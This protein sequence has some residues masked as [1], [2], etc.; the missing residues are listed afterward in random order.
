MSVPN[1]R[2]YDDSFIKERLDEMVRSN[3]TTFEIVSWFYRFGF[4]EGQAEIVKSHYERTKHLSE[5]LRLIK[6][7]QCLSAML[8]IPNFQIGVDYAWEHAIKLIELNEQEEKR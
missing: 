6:E 7:N 5:Q 1:S 3:W 2:A 4:K 8:A